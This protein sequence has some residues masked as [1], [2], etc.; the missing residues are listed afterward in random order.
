MIFLGA[1]T[2]FFLPWINRTWHREHAS[3]SEGLSTLFEWSAK[4]SLTGLFILLFISWPQGLG[5]GLDAWWFKIHHNIGLNRKQLFNTYIVLK[6]VMTVI[7]FKT[8]TESS[9]NFYKTLSLE[10]NVIYTS[11]DNKDTLWGWGG[12]VI[13]N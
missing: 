1:C 6:K 2:S 8:N 4:I 7:C 10:I 13:Y 3:M 5:R 12:G 11:L 9:L